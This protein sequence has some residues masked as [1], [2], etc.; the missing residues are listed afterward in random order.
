MDELQEQLELG[1]QAR[2]FEMYI[3]MTP[4][5]NKLVERIKLKYAA[6]ILN[7]HPTQKDEFVMNRCGIITLDDL[8]NTIISDIYIG[9]QADNAMSG[10]KDDKG[11]L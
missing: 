6:D 2:E 7:L 4:Y 8:M 5:F 9:E 10:V 11:L 3:N 1:R